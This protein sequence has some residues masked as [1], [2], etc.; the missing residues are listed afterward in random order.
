MRLLEN[1]VCGISIE[2]F[3]ISSSLFS[4]ERGT[5]ITEDDTR[6]FCNVRGLESGHT[7][8]RWTPGKTAIVVSFKSRKEDI[9]LAK[10]LE[11]LK[12]DAKRQFTRQLPALICVHMAD[13]SE[14]QLLDIA[15]VD[16]S[17]TP[18]GIRIV[19]SKLLRERPHVHTVALMTDGSVRVEQN[20]IGNLCTNFTQETGP[21]Y[22]VRNSD[23]PQANDLVLKSVFAPLS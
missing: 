23:H 5:T 2:R 11:R 14:K 4:A 16:K 21:T 18:T 17:E 20:Q 3:D 22:I 15:E 9:V 6:E 13:L 10:I 12:E 1:E 7:F 19:L 8:F